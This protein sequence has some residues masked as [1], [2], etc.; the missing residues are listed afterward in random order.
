MT[1][2]IRNHVGM[3]GPSLDGESGDDVVGSGVASS[4]GVSGT[5]VVGESG[6]GVFVWI[7]GG[8][9]AGVLTSEVGSVCLP[10]SRT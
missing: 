6:V 2:P 8:V 9:F 1:R 5:V 3:S 4:V 7:E 10:S